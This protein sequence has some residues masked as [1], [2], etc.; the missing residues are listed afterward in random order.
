MQQQEF[1]K[2]MLPVKD[3]IYRFAKR[4]LISH[5]EAEDAVQEVFIK[6]WKQSNKL[7]QLAKP[8]AFAMTVTKNYC[9]D[10]LKSKQSSQVQLV[11]THH[12]VSRNEEKQMENR[13]F[14][15]MVFEFMQVLPEK[16][17]MVMQLR[18]VEG[19]EYEEVAQIMEMNETAVRVTLSRARKAIRER[20]IKKE[21]YGIVKD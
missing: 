12:P 10:R 4:L 11:S 14:T 1:V 18:D 13:D 15:G 17:R 2:L 7:S 5:D 8:E 9:L 3:K 19:Y 16:Q 20:L 21:N 6:L